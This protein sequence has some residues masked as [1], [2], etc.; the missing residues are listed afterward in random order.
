MKGTRLQLCASVLVYVQIIQHFSKNAESVMPEKNNTAV[1]I[2]ETLSP[3][4]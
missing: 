4:L 3:E 2:T 1:D